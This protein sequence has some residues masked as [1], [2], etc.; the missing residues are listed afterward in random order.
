MGLLVD[1]G[2][3]AIAF[4]GMEGVA[5]FTHKYVMHGF[6]WSWHKDHHDHKRTLF[7]VNDLF[8]VVFS[9]PAIVFII[10][11]LNYP[12]LYFLFPLGIG[13]TFYGVFY[14][15]FHDVIVHRRIKLPFKARSDY[16]KRIMS[17]HYHHHTKHSREDCEAFGFLYAPKKYAPRRSKS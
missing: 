1:I 8:S 11:G 10:I 3:V 4:F 13:I 17:A 16:M 15:V 14:F 7:E 5:W 9:I 12:S 6:L 2:L